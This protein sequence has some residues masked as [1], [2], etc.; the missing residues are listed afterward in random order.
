MWVYTI[1]ALLLH[2]CLPLPTYLPTYLGEGM[3]GRGW[4]AN[5]GDRWKGNE[6][7]FPEL[8]ETWESEQG[9]LGV[10]ANREYLEV[11]RRNP[12]APRRNPWG[13]NTFQQ[14]NRPYNQYRTNSPG[15]GWTRVR[16][17]LNFPCPQQFFLKIF[18]ESA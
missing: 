12:W 16:Q 11:N 8:L 4:G 15:R 6:G 13:Q 9:D 14:P 18:R 17:N 2:P 3:G 7:E 1:L 5:E 10:S